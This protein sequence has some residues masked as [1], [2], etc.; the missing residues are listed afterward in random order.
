[1]IVVAF[2]WDKSRYALPCC[3]QITM[4]SSLSNFLPMTGFRFSIINMQCTCYCTALLQEVCQCNIVHVQRNINIPFELMG[5]LIIFGLQWWRMR[6]PFAN[7]C[8]LHHEVVYPWTIACRS[9]SQKIIAFC[10]M[11]SQQSLACIEAHLFH[12]S[13][14][15]E[16][17]MHNLC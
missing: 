17:N 12:I 7:S 8:G 16:P 5:L 4:D 6:P 3:K 13:T 14:D 15:V 9:Q 2:T 10:F 1:M 11:V